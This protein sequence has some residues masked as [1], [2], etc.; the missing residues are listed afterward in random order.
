MKL[1]PLNAIVLC[2]IA[3]ASCDS[4]QT[5]EHSSKTV[6]NIKTTSTPNTIEGKVDALLTQMTLAEKI[7]QMTQAERKHAS[8]DDVKKYFLGSILNGGGSVPGDNKVEDWRAM[9]DGYQVAA[10]STR[11]SIPM[12]YGT[13]AV[14][15][16]NNVVNATIFPHNIA[17]GAM[18]NPD[19]LEK[20]ASAT[21]KEV[22]ATGVHWNFAPTLCVSQDDRW[23]RAY[24]C[25][26][27]HPEIATSYSGKIVKGMQASGNV[28]ATAKH[29]V[30]DGGTSYGTG[31][32]EYIMDRGNTQVT[33][34]ELRNTHI[35]PYLPALAANVGTVMISYSSVNGLKMH[36]HKRLTTDVLKTELGF[37]G[38]TIS[39]WQAIEE[40]NGEMN[41]QRVVSAIN[42][43][44][45]MAME[46]EFWR[47][48]ISDL[49]AAVNDGEV[50]M[51]RINDAVRRILTVK[52]QAGLFEKPL[53]TD[54][55]ADY[56]GVLGNAEHREI[57]L[58]AVRES[59][60]IL[61]NV[62][63]NSGT[64]AEQNNQS[65]LLPL[66]KNAKVFVAGM[67]ADN[68]G[69]QSG[70][71]TVEWQGKLGAI[72]QGTTILSG[73]ENL[74]TNKVTYSENGNGASGHDVAIVV[75]GEQPYAEG[76][77][78]YQEQPCEFCQPL[79]LVKEQLALIEKVQATGVPTVVVLVSG[80]P[81][82]ITEH[83]NHW[84]TLVA[85]W[86]PGSEGAG[87]ADVLFGDYKPS[88]KLP[89][90]WPKTLEQVTL[91]V[92][93]DNYTPLFPYGFGL[94]Y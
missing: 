21:A 66:S 43:G 20:I 22:A 9:I 14:H 35:A 2:C 36:E 55:L 32:H 79:T 62:N 58:Q 84:D 93:D 75:V 17:L 26:G 92:G 40:V 6:D 67:H 29:W 5:E 54:R 31:D 57:A 13:D 38:F 39:D 25:F 89:V 11:L 16:H 49:T 10:L 19:L 65:A 30:G 77:G 72:T 76:W 33:E 80:R 88:G 73:I 64:T 18:R 47:E 63:T 45:D 48:F 82:L 59:L 50:A 86:L 78:D 69:L 56:Q 85:A 37:K 28:I 15:G 90:T 68:I 61:K 27:E 8:P 23:G 34:T 52:I 3:L 94:T 4:P 83:I 70:G 81:L 53:S 24:E 71:W 51:S 41:R 42:S 1:L 87:V 12:I 91:N 46:P 74:T 44:I 7:G 60:V